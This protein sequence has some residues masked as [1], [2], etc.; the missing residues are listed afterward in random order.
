MNSSSGRE[1]LQA[2]SFA[3]RAMPAGHVESLAA[4][5]ADSP[6][7]DVGV[8][9]KALASVG[10]PAYR[11]H[12][13]SFFEAW[14]AEPAVPGYAVSLSLR[15][16]A[17][18]REEAH[19]EQTIEVVWTGPTSH[20]VPM[21]RTREVLLELIGF[22]RERLTVVSFAAY[23][24]PEVLAA[25]SA[26]AQRGV[27]VRLVLEST[28][29][30][31]GRLTHDAAAAFASLGGAVTFYV[32]PLDRR[33]ASEARSGSLH[34]KAVVADAHAAFVTSAN[35]TGQALNA[36]M[37]LGLLVQG[38]TVPMRLDAHFDELI[39]QGMLREVK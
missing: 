21:R 33:P 26:A 39:A 12:V 11:R 32:W 38:G 16:A 28:E 14:A 19:A 9:G 37:E 2:I 35:L 3:V 23:K 5:I 4:T 15:A 7:Y 10:N 34:A 24:V 36:N 6:R 31:Q 13:R 29:D 17:R 22:A 25:L 27:D 8:E 18:A 30:S 1:F 20:V